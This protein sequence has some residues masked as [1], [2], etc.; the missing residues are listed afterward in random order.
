MNLCQLGYC[1]NQ[2]GS[3]KSMLFKKSL[4]SAE[5]H[6]DYTWLVG[7][8]EQRKTKNLK[9]KDYEDIVVYHYSLMRPKESLVVKYLFYINL[10]YKTNKKNNNLFIKSLY[11]QNIPIEQIKNI[12]NRSRIEG[13]GFPETQEINNKW[14]KNTK[15]EKQQKKI[16]NLI[17]NL[18]FQESDFIA[19]DIPMFGLIPVGKNYSNIII[20]LEESVDVFEYTLCPIYNNKL[21][22]INKND[23]V[24][25]K[26]KIGINFD[27]N[28][29]ICIRLDIKDKSKIVNKIKRIMYS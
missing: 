27:K 25:D 10:W 24:L 7:Y 21:E 12:F 9:I 16:E 26:N 28:K 8:D 22:I 14:I 29:I 4:V 18:D 5:D 17:K 11:N 19:S 15:L 6:L 3:K 2:K 20:E 1:F 23:K 13:L